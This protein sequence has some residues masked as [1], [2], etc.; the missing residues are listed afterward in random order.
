MPTCPR[1]SKGHNTLKIIGAHRPIRCSGAIR[2]A[3]LRIGSVLAQICG[4]T[5]LLRG[6][7]LRTGHFGP[8]PLARNDAFGAFTRSRRGAA[9]G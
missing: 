7:C 9:P 4:E 2:R 1:G 5:E 6:A 8:D 3:S